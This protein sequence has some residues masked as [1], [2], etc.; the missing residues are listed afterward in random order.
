MIR[1]VSELILLIL[2]FG[3]ISII[4]K[5]RYM[6]GLSFKQIFSFFLWTFKYGD[7][8]KWI[9]DEPCWMPIQKLKP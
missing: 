4:P 7:R 2:V 6:V 5:T 3:F 9:I 1:I 8:E